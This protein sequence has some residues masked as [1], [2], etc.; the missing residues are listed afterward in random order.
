M[1]KERNGEIEK[2]MCLV[3]VTFS[4]KKK[5]PSKRGAPKVYLAKR[6]SYWFKNF[7]LDFFL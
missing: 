6:F 4:F 7:V 5:E 3:C 2:V 1:E